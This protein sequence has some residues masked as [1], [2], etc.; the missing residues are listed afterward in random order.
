MNYIVIHVLL[1]HF[2]YLKVYFLEGQKVSLQFLS[3]ISMSD[4][5]NMFQF[6][7]ILIIVSEALH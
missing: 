6:S 2:Y 5:S 1:R 4:K 3:I 7:C